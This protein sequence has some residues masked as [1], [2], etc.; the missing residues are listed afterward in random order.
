[1]HVEGSDLAS[2][3]RIDHYLLTVHVLHQFS[4]DGGIDP[5]LTEIKFHFD[6]SCHE[7]GIQSHSIHEYIGVVEVHSDFVSYTGHQQLVEVKHFDVGSEAQH[8]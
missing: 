3:R 1:M 4:V 2:N 8:A 5:A 7:S 6:I